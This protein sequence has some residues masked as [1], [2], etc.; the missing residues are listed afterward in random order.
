VVG[1]KFMKHGTA[2]SLSN[3]YSSERKQHDQK[4]PPNVMGATRSS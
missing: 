2:H 4:S 3:V 1:N